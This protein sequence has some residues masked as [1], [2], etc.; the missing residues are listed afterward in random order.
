MVVLQDV[1]GTFFTASAP[2]NFVAYVPGS[3]RSLSD[4]GFAEGMT[5]FVDLPQRVEF[6]L[7]TGAGGTMP[8][9][10]DRITI[11]GC[12]FCGGSDGRGAIRFDSRGRATFHNANGAPLDLFG[13]SFSIHVVT[14]VASTT[15]TDQGTRTLVLTSASGA[16]RTF[17]R[18]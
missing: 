7:D 6:G 10:Y 1:P 13:A 16:V 17:T 4:V 3:E 11:A 8:A 5:D 18:G 9:P 2:T 15:S 12:S 14:D